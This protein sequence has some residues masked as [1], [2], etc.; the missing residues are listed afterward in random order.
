MDWFAVARAAQVQRTHE[1]NMLLAGHELPPRD[2]TPDDDP[3]AGGF[4]GGARQSVPPRPP[5]H[6]QW[7][8]WVLAERRADVGRNFSA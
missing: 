7:L 3:R 1:L 6:E 2:A 5:T 4:D 8:T